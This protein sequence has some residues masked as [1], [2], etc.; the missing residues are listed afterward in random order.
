MWE[1][2]SV[3]SGK[4]DFVKPHGKEKVN[5]NRIVWSRGITTPDKHLS[6][7]EECSGFFPGL[8]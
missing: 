1:E 6:T 3:N 2:G 8:D 5:S 4:K 7:S